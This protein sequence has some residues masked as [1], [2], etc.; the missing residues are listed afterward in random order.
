MSTRFWASVA[1]ILNLVLPSIGLARG[2]VVAQAA[3]TGAGPNPAE[4]NKAKAEAL[5]KNG[6]VAFDDGEYEKAA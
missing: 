4:I 2:P 1:L 5:Y 6:Q 3:T